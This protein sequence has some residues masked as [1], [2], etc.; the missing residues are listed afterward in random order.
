MAYQLS[1]PPVAFYCID[2]SPNLI[3]ISVL[4]FANLM[5]IKMGLL[6]FSFKL[7]DNIIFKIIIRFLRRSLA[8]L[9]GQSA[10]APSQLTAT[11]T[12]RDQAILLP[13]PPKQLDYRHI[14]PC[15]ANFYIFV[16][17][18]F[19]HVGQDGLNI[20]TLW[21]AR[22]GLPKCWDCKREP[23]RLAS[24]KEQFF[25]VI[26]VNKAG[27]GSSLR[28]IQMVLKVYWLNGNIYLKLFSNELVQA[29]G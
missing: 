16:E 9:P 6:C 22:L 15:A 19:H 28:G 10:V 27:I 7:K 8:L 20:L 24:R 17:M 11:S 13:Q 1:L 26:S 23:P 14:P 18:G 12:S 4:I 3:L 25:I 5:G 29:Q 2:F 21:S